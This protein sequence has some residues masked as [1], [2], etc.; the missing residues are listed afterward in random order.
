MALALSGHL[1]AAEYQAG[2]LLG[3]R[4]MLHLGI[5][6]QAPIVSCQIG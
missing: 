2:L 3:E 4:A 5:L 6:G 1:A